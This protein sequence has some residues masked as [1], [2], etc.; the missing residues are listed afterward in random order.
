MLGLAVVC[1]AIWKS[2]NAVCFEKKILRNP[3]KIV[4]SACAFMRYWASLYPGITKEVIEEG[5]DVMLWTAIKLLGR[6]KGKTLGMVLMIED[7]NPQNT[8][9]EDPD[10]SVKIV[11]E[12]WKLV[13][14]ALLHCCCLFCYDGCNGL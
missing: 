7:K 3:L 9:D 8:E 13:D 6:K 5:V 14:V 10:G 11:W 12:P 4:C 1:W 2:R